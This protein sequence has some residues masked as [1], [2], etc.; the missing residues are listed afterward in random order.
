MD[1]LE[2]RTPLLKQAGFI[3][4]DVAKKMEAELA[5]RFTPYLNDSG[6]SLDKVG[7]SQFEFQA[8][9]EEDFKNRTGLGKFSDA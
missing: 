2:G 4:T 1:L 3:S 7:V 9:S 5:P 6:T 8:Q